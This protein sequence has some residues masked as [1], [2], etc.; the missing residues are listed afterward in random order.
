MYLLKDGRLI[1]S[2]VIVD[3]DPTHTNSVDRLTT[4]EFAKFVDKEII[5][6]VRVM[7]VTAKQARLALL[8]YGI[9]DQVETAIKVATRDIQIT[10]EFAETVHRDAALVLSIGRSLGLT[11]D[12]IVGLFNLASTL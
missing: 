6:P 11:S 3:F 5:E 9:L 10:W 8:Q 1:G 7:V 2:A 4:E 12:Q